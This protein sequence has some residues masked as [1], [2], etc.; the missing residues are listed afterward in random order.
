MT[1]IPTRRKYKKP[2]SVLTVNK[3][4]K[5][6]NEYKEIIDH[7]EEQ[8]INI[9]RTRKIDDSLLNTEFTLPLKCTKS[10]NCSFCEEAHKNTQCP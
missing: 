10:I 2:S 3:P 5:K 9:N 6:K 8:N 4:K 1:K 7:K